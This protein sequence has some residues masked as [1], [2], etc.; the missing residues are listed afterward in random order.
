[1]DEH[2]VRYNFR[3][4]EPDGDKIVQYP[5]KIEGSMRLQ[6]ESRKDK[7]KKLDERKKDEEKIFRAEADKKKEE[8]KNNILA[9]IN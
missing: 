2:E 5:R 6:T 7:R 8:L 1:M 9:K 4:E 3:Y